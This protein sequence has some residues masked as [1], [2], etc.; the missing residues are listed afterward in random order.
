MPSARFHLCL[1]KRG[2]NE[3]KTVDVNGVLL[4]IYCE[5]CDDPERVGAPLGC[6]VVDYVV[7]GGCVTAARPAGRKRYKSCVAPPA[8]IFVFFSL[9][10]R[11]T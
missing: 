3:G 2:L 7:N 8:D 5:L 1:G 10:D 4:A 9:S 11:P 6:A